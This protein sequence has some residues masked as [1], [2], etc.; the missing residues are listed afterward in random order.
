[1]SRGL[2][3]YT[4]GEEIANAVTHAVA[5]GLSIAGL[6]ALAVLGVMRGGTAG[7]IASLVVYGS[8]LV[9]THLASTLYHSFRGRRV[10]AVFRILDHA[11]IYLLIAGTYTPFLVIRL[12]NP[13]GWTLLGIVWAM[14]I[15]GVVFKSVFLGRLRKA[16]LVTYVAMGWLVVVAARQFIVHVPLGALVFLL[17]GGVIYTLGI[18]FYAWKRLPFNHAIWHL[19]VLAAAMSHY[20]AIFLYLL[21]PP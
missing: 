6:A 10:K 19:M 1:M 5:T 14:A 18:V 17:I 2:P 3:E 16:S 15:A 20:F 9:L 21:P 4:D 11:S 13:W 8:T 12:W 7:Q